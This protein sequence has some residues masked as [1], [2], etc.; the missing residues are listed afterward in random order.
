MKYWNEAM[1]CI[2]RGELRALQTERLIRTVQRVYDHAPYYREK[3]AAAGVTPADIKSIDD[4]SRLPFT[5]KVDLRA[6]Y[7]FDTFTVPLEEVVRIQASS[8]TTGK[9]TVAG[10]T[11]NDL[12]VWSECTAR[13]LSGVG[14]GAGDIIHVAYGY[15]LFTGGLGAHGGSE[16]IGAVTVPASGG[17]TARQIQL[18][19]DFGA[20]ALC[21]TPSY[22]LF[23]ADELVK[24]G[25]SKADLK[26]KA[27]IFGAEPW[28][29]EMRDQLEE[30]LGL[31]AYDIYGLTEI[32]GPGVAMR[33]PGC[34]GLHVMADHFYPEIIHPETG[35]VLPEG[36]T[37]E[38]VFT[39]IT[40]EAMPLIRYRTR[41][42]TRLTYE[43]CPHCG[44][45]LP[46]MDRVTGRTD[47][48][49][50]IRGVNVF[51]SQIESV[52]LKYLEIEPHYMIYV[53]R[54]NNLDIMEIQIEMKADLFT[55]EVR[56]IE[57]LEG[58]LARDIDSALGISA[59]VKLVEPMTIKR[60]EGKA[61]RVVDERNFA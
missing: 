37:G 23:I 60:S 5:Y 51:P 36:E 17:N 29:A 50:I 13:C 44:R 20:T 28:T 7:P 16:K 42:L 8:G 34:S 12:E 27:G 9:Q 39:C 54:L 24:Q 41:D 19:V 43:R 14:L 61:V 56:K 4:I 3:M 45:T 11:R 35:E 40:K 33:F 32:A 22:A 59:K 47:D 57:E 38:L 48:M 6:N 25:Y 52:L 49:L 26:L 55:D 31:Q 2:D 10:Y 53:R 30:K 15:G 18:L 1:E 58:R 21:C 46:R